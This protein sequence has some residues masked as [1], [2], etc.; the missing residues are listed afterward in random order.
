M[1]FVFI[2]RQT[3]EHMFLI[4]IFAQKR[5]HPNV[6]RKNININS[7]PALINLKN[8]NVILILT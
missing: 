3:D 4:N 5:N 1:L 8:Y 7:H 6:Q 2:K